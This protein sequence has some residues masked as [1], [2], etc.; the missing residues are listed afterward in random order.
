MMKKKRVMGGAAR[1][2]A[3]CMFG[4]KILIKKSPMLWLSPTQAQ[5]V[6][7]RT[8]LRKLTKSLVSNRTRPVGNNS[9]TERQ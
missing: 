7:P 1:I 2:K 5:V 8:N 6:T 9:I 3:I 4:I